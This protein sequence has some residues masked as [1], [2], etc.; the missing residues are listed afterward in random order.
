MIR[1]SFAALCA[2]LL[3]AAAAH[4]ASPGGVSPMQTITPAQTTEAL[5]NPGMGLYE[6]GTLNPDDMPADAWYRDL[7]AI[8]YFRDDWAEVEPVRE[9]EYR[10]DEY[11]GPIFD[12]WV[13]QW[14]K[15]VAFR[16]MCSNMHSRLEYVTP[17]WVFDAGVPSVVHKGL[18]VPRQVDPVFWDER[19]LAIQERFITDLGKYLDGRPGLEFIDIGSIGEWGEMHLSRWTP[20]ELRRTGYTDDRYIA[21]YRRIIDAFARAF[22]HTRVFLNV[23]DFTAINDYAA[24]RG[25]NFRQDGLTPSGP[26]AD[27]GKRFY[28]P[29]APKGVICNYEFHSGYEEM[30]RRGWGLR[31][32]FNKGLEDPISYL[33]LN[34]T[35]YSQL[36]H[37][38]AELKECILDAARRIGF[39]F[40][41]DRLT[42]NEV[43][44]MDGAAPGRLVLQH[45][46]RNLGVAPCYDSYALRW[47]LIDGGG[48]AVAQTLTFPKQPTTLWSPG[49]SV[50]LADMMPVPP[51]TPPGVYHLTVEM[52]KPEEPG[53]HIQLGIAGRDAEGRYGL[54]TVR[55]ERAAPVAR[56]VYR[57]SF[58]KSIA[59]WR[60]APGMSLAQGRDEGS[61]S[62]TLRISGLQ[63]GASWQYAS[64]QIAAVPYSRYRLTCWMKVDRIDSDQAPY[65]KLGINARDRWITNLNTNAYDL[66]RLGTWQRLET[67]GDTAPDAATIDIAV[68]RGVLEPSISIDLQLRDV[69][70]K[71]LE[72]P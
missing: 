12:L 67:E 21:A 17:K 57:S 44:R 13:K 50:A 24:L 66:D 35:W 18:Y 48:K 28:Q 45:T 37:P 39:R 40:V 49:E 69:T 30:Q 29:Y 27:V 14:H 59:A 55:L 58:D 42:C 11:F 23:G 3:L 72:S 68:E 8:G 61:G 71:L 54:G 20:E 53:V 65:L 16:F 34:V 41:L 32:T 47:S 6:G 9:G 70:V 4:A 63:P 1:P 62:G 56:V 22:P 25:L 51:A 52:V 64:T 36:Q 19:Y 46:W 26:S 2:L 60:P 7:I 15:R 10:F 5:I 31:E 38:P 43:V 33:H